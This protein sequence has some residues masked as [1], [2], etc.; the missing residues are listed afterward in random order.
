MEVTKCDRCGAY[1]D[2]FAGEMPT[3]IYSY[4]HEKYM[5]GDRVT[6]ELCYNCYAELERWLDANE[7]ESD[8][9]S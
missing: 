5:Q 3:L 8:E 7:E 1:V 4:S 6:K 9:N 2:K